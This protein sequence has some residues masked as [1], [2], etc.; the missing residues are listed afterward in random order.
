MITKT[1]VCDFCGDK[2]KT[3]PSVS[4]PKN[5]VDISL[6]CEA[7]RPISKEICACE[8]CADQALNRVE[9][10]LDGIK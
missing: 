7:K 4:C 5:W 3:E 2:Q 1:F 10:L 6:R 9:V 8:K